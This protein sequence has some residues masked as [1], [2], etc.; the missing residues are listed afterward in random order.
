MLKGPGK[1][2]NKINTRVSKI[3]TNKIHFMYKTYHTVEANV[4]SK[5][6]IRH[7]IT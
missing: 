1:Q 5:N 6:H 3:K 4:R 2:E 7:T